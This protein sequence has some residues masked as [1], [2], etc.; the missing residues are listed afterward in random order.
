MK[1]K[2]D[3]D[4]LVEIVQT[5]IVY[6][7]SNQKKIAKNENGRR[8]DIVS[9]FNLIVEYLNVPVAVLDKDVNCKYLL[10]YLNNLQEKLKN[11]F[12]KVEENPEKFM[13]IVGDINLILSKMNTGVF[14]KLRDK[15][16]IT[17][18][19]NSI[20]TIIVGNLQSQKQ[21]KNNN[22]EKVA[23]DK[24]KKHEGD[25]YNNKTSLLNL[26][27]EILFEISE[28][29]PLKDLGHFLSTAKNI[30]GLDS[31]AL[32]KSIRTNK[33]PKF[34][35]FQ[36]ESEKAAVKRASQAQEG[37]FLYYFTY[38]DT[39]YDPMQVINNSKIIRVRRIKCD[40]YLGDLIKKANGIRRQGIYYIVQFDLNAEEMNK[41]YAQIKN[42]KLEGKEIVSITETI[43]SHIIKVIPSKDIKYYAQSYTESDLNDVILVKFNAKTNKLEKTGTEKVDWSI[44][45]KTNPNFATDAPQN[46]LS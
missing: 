38:D 25:N 18:D 10:G 33:Y 36:G 16:K 15:I 21:I 45:D 34:S 30:Q 35:L 29:L 5:L 41:L 17:L 1:F 20:S 7:N 14:S 3:I 4:F 27:N 32:W 11:N 31:N 40:D 2:N 6:T 22:K 46:N 44:F 43:K 13:K 9:M 42:R 26:P 24:E 28:S 23:Q 37:A 39:K 12:F 8:H 19:N